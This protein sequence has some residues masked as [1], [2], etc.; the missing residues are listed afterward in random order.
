MLSEEISLLHYDLHKYIHVYIS[1]RGGWD[2][3]RRRT[4]KKDEEG[5]G[6]EKER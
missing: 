6:E 5:E 1:L 4:G 2:G 3:G